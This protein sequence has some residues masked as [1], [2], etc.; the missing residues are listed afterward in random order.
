M[1]RGKGK[2]LQFTE[3]ETPASTEAKFIVKVSLSLHFTESREPPHLRQ[4]TCK[5]QLHRSRKQQQVFFQLCLC[6]CSSH[7]RNLV[8]R[9][10][11]KGPNLIIIN[12]TSNLIF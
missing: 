4:V 7:S 11:A 1:P 9:S 2:A 8:R 5:R 10:I 12:N 3:T 6:P